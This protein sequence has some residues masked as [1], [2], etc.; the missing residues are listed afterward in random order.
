MRYFGGFNTFTRNIDRGFFAKTDSAVGDSDSSNSDSN[1]SNSSSSDSDSGSDSDGES[2]VHY[3]C[4]AMRHNPNSGCNAECL[5]HSDCPSFLHCC[6]NGCGYGCMEPH[7]IPFIDLSNSTEDEDCPALYDVPCLG[8]TEYDSCSNGESDCDDT[9]R[10]C[11]N[12]C[13]GAI[14]VPR[15]PC[16]TAVDIANSSREGVRDYRPQC[17]TQGT[18]RKIQCHSYYC[19]CVDVMSGVPQSDIVPFEEMNVLPCTGN[20]MPVVTDTR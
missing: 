16:F 15:T 10:C 3:S 17:T 11:E 5:T 13:G 8:E 6:Y 9:E 1:S 12:D 4:P 2:R 20:S 19:W 7:I 18:F 14:C